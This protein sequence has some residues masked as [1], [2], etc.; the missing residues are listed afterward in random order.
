MFTVLK[1]LTWFFREHKKRYLTALV[2]L[3]AMNVLEVIPPML[4]GNA[5]D[6]M[7]QGTLTTRGL[8]DIVGIYALLVVVV[9]FSTYAWMYQLFGGGFLLQRTLRSRL[10]RQ[11]LR[12]TPTF[13]EKNRTGDLMARATNDL[14]AV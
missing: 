4:V 13:F 9:Y 3:L 1:K 5:I 7:N 6:E 12:K 10:M 11:F 2:L 14:T 8:L